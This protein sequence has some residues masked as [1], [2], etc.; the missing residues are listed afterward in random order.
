[1]YEEHIMS[2]HGFDIMITYILIYQIHIYI[3]IIIIQLTW[4]PALRPE[5]LYERL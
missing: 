2:A 1:M 5:T 4:Q 3:H